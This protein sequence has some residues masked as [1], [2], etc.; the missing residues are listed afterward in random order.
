M[1]KLLAAVAIAT[2]A[3]TGTSFAGDTPSPPGASVLFVNLQVG[4]SVF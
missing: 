2:L 3:L 4:A 1:K